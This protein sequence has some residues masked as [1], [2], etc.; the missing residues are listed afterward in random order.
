LYNYFLYAG[1]MTVNL[2]TT[3]ASETFRALMTAVTRVNAILADEMDGEIGMSLERYGILLMLSQAEDGAMRPSE[4]A[5][6]LPLT[7]SGITRLVDRVERDGLIER[8]SCPTDRRGNLVAL[9]SEGERAFRKAGRVHLRGIDE[10]IGSHLTEHELAQLGAL[11]RK[12]ADGVGG[13]ALSAFSTS[14]PS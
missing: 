5:D 10:H 1:S 9:T 11:L 6:S 4:L 13:R 14:D 2:R 12:L 7:R 8:R 3:D